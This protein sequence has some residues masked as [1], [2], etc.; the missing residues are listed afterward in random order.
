MNHLTRTRTMTKRTKLTLLGAACLLTLIAVGGCGED[1]NASGPKADTKKAVEVD[2]GTAAEVVSSCKGVGQEHRRKF[3]QYDHQCGFLSDCAASG[4]CSCGKGCAA[5][6]Q[7]C[8]DTLCKGA[9][10]ACYCG[11]DCVDQPSKKPL[12]PEYFCKENNKHQV[13]GCHALPHCKFIDTPQNS[14]CQC[15]TMPNHA[16]TCW[17]G[18]TCADGKAK[19]SG[20]LCFGKNP[21]ACI[22]TP[23]EKYDACYCATCGLKANKPACFFVLCP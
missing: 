10:P 18:D 22:V 7:P 12:C 11:D 19:C 8:N 16:P 13:A 4:Q 2:A 21:N 9:D 23:G 15:T 14:K 1:S 5:D 20:A 6:T 3:S 17:C